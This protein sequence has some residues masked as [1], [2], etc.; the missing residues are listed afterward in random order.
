LRLLHTN[1][2]EMEV[3]AVWY[4][5][6]L[7]NY[8]T[9]K[10]A[11]SMAYL[12]K[13]L[14]MAVAINGRNHLQVAEALYRKGQVLY[15]TG[16]LAESMPILSEA[17]ETRRQKLGEFHPAVADSYCLIGKV[18]L[19]T[20]ELDFAF[21]AFEKGLAVQRA[22]AQ[23]DVSFDIAQTLLEMGRIQHLKGRLEQAVEI[24]VEVHLLTTKFFGENHLFVARIS[25]ILGNLYSEIGNL[26]TSNDYLN[27]ALQI[28]D[29]LKT[30]SS[31][32]TNTAAP[33]ETNDPIDEDI[34]DDENQSTASPSA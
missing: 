34:E 6:A 3:A 21:V 33:P 7:L 12:D 8:Y 9:G 5:S 19:D 10:K 31:V 15:E 20:K 24:Y 1:M 13:F 11:E 30:T 2:D 32:N 16:K 28:Q 18:L 14:T 27:E 17:L 4:N 29:K 25:N 26:D 23:D 22:L